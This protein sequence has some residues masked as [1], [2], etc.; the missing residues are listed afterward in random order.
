MATTHEAMKTF[1]IR[2]RTEEFRGITTKRII[3]LGL[4]HDLLSVLNR[5]GY[6]VIQPPDP[7]E[8]GINPVINGQIDKSKSFAFMSE[9][10]IFLSQTRNADAAT[11]QRSV[12]IRE[13]ASNIGT[14][15]Q[16]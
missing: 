5:Q 8:S 4:R 15:I 7:D 11:M 10:L 9:H 3:T 2:T 1:Y 13:V 12:G 6:W 14:C 16:S